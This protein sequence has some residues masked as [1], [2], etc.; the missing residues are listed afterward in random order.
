MPRVK[1]VDTLLCTFEAIHDFELFK[2]VSATH[3]AVELRF[4]YLNIRQNWVLQLWEP[5]VLWSNSPS[6]NHV[7]NRQVLTSA[8][9]NA[10]TLKSSLPC[11][12]V[13]NE[14]DHE[15]QWYKER[16]IVMRGDAWIASD[17]NMPTPVEVVLPFR[18]E[19]FWPS[20]VPPSFDDIKS[21]FC[22]FSRV[23]SFSSY[24]IYA[25][26]LPIGWQKKIE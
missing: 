5:H 20:F 4:C 14:S 24:P 9:V 17:K 10:N 2:T 18:L 21:F 6:S 11:G 15:S 13:S 16:K 23:F 22:L 19:Q 1:V 3:Y 8:H 12:C 26:L 7:D 25:T